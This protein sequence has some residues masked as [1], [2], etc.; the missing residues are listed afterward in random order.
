MGEWDLPKDI[1]TQSIE[2]VGGGFLW[3]SGVYDTTIKMVYLNQTKS[4]AMWFNV[5]LTKNSGD[6]KEL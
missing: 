1:E 4:E 5:I 2:R 6:M 3:E